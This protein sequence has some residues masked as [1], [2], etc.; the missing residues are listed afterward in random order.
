MKS[1][2]VKQTETKDV[3]LKCPNNCNA[4]LEIK[5]DHPCTPL[6]VRCTKCSKTIFWSD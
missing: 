6:L 1:I 4:E 2:I 3:E 5:R